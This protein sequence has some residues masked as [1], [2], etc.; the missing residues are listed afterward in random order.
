M[1]FLNQS[2]TLLEVKAETVSVIHALPG[3]GDLPP[4]DEDPATVTNS[5]GC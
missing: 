2:P 1:L 5:G 4:Q 3:G